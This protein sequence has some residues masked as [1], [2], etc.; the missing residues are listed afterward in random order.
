MPYYKFGLNDLFY[1]NLKTHPES[2]FV[3]YDNDVFYNNKSAFSGNYQSNVTHVP[4]G[5]IS[6]YELNVDRPADKLIYPFITK[7]GS[8]SSFSTV[9]TSNFN[10][11]FAYGDEIT[12][13]YPLSASV[14]SERF[15][16][17]ATRTKI[18][19]LRNPLNSYRILSPHYGYDTT[20]FGDK[21]TQEL[22][23][24]SVPSIFYGSSIEKGTVSLKFFVTGTQ[25]AELKDDKKNG[26]L[27]QATSGS[28][29]DS[30]SVAGVVLYKEG[31]ILLTGSWN[32][33]D[34]HTEDYTGGGASKPRWIDFA[35]KK[36]GIQNSAFKMNFSG[37]NYVPTLTM[38]ANAPKGELNHSNNPTYKS[39]VTSSVRLMSSGSQLYRE[40]NKIPITNIASSSFS[41]TNKTFEKITFIN[42]I[43]IYDKDKNLIAVAKMANPVRKKELDDYTFKLKLDF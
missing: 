26:E 8:L 10:S 43:G 16:E 20:E 27:R 17:N 31:F 36:T 35:T 1:N 34:K 13:S 22:R 15:A 25:I 42:Q 37:T 30:G 40:H 19:A 11:N 23:L 5:N 3:I 24:I 21:S 9:S 6:L 28:G 2:E 32:L 33:T 14:S 41:G 4:V 7:A 39:Y 38:F 12:G 18:T 29:A